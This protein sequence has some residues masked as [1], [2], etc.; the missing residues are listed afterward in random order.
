MS[1]RSK[2]LIMKPWTNSLGSGQEKKGILMQTENC[3]LFLS[4]VNVERK[5]ADKRGQQVTTRVYCQ[6]HVLFPA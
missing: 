5:T 2:T 1:S 6:L 3:F 4:L